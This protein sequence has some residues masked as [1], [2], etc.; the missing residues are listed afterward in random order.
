MDIAT[1]F[2]ILLNRIL[3]FRNQGHLG[4]EWPWRF[5]LA[6]KDF[7]TRAT[8]FR[9]EAATKIEIQ[10]RIIQPSDGSLPLA[11]FDGATHSAILYPSRASEI[12]FCRRSNAPKEC[13]AGG[14]GFDPEIPNF[15]I[16]SALEA[17]RGESNDLHVYAKVDIPLP[18]YVGLEEI[19]TPIYFPPSS[20]H[21]FLGI[22]SK[23][24]GWNGH[25][26]IPFEAAYSHVYGHLVSYRYRRRANKRK[27]NTKTILFAHRSSS[28]HGQ[29][30]LE[31]RIPSTLELFIDHGCKGSSNFGSPFKLTEEE[32]DPDSIADEIWEFYV[33]KDRIYNPA[34]ERLPFFYDHAVPLRAVQAGEQI[35]VNKLASTGLNE[36]AWKAEVLALREKCSRTTANM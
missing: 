13:G 33:G 9:N 19:S 1:L 21:T 32:A 27:M 30:E 10:K 16:D 14:H 17:R 7:D 6:F 35:L 31:A 18:S 3:R 22:G 20:Y 23:Y 2:E 8:W 12:E 25:A 36:F 26:M 28:S 11:Y 15:M 4:Y 34:A 29:G 24:Y 5:A